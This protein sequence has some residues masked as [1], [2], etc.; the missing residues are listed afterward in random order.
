MTCACSSARN[1]GTIKT[2]ESPNAGD[3]M[4]SWLPLHCSLGVFGQWYQHS[5]DKKDK[6]FCI[7]QTGWY[8]R[9][10][11]HLQQQ[12]K[13]PPAGKH[14][15]RDTWQDWTELKNMLVTNQNPPQHHTGII[16][17]GHD[18]RQR[19]KVTWTCQPSTRFMLLVWIT[20]PISLT[21]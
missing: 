3:V 15:N 8:L 16:D 21:R 6:T 19:K 11:L 2:P 12:Q 10:H 1:H 5:A 20:N 9:E 4:L 7:Y 13:P 17:P 18:P 14:N